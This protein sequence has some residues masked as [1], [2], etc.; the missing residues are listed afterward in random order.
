V[1]TPEQVTEANAAEQAQ[2]LRREIEDAG[3]EGLTPAPAARKPAQ[4]KE[5]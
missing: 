3:R 2:A 4:S 5:E 1:V